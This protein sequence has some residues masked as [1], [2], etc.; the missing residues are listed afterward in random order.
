MRDMANV[1]RDLVKAQ[2]R[3]ERANSDAEF[4]SAQANFEQVEA[5]WLERGEQLELAKLGD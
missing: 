4:L 3:L 1:Y 5:E 2:E